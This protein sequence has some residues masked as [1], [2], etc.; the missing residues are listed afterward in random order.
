MLAIEHDWRMRKLLQ[1]NLESLGLDVQAAVSGQDA[2]HLL[3]QGT[4][5]LILLSMDQPDS[6]ASH[7]LE[8]LHTQLPDRVPIIVMTA[9][10]PSRSLVR[11]K[12]RTRYLLKPFAVPDL[13]LSVG[14]ALDGATS[15]MQGT[16][17]DR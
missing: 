2:L 10:P 15:G 13:L 9:E 14:Q 4:P 6:D 1:A 3:S 8:H 7:L 17:T 5:D 16:T 12:S 11:D